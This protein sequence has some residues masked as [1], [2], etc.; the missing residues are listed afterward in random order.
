L[1]LFFK[2]PFWDFK[3]WKSQTNENFELEKLFAWFSEK[4]N[5]SD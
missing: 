3:K 4:L 5:K 1:K 2:K